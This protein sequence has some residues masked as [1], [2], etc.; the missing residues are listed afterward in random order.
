MAPL[1][2]DQ[3]RTLTARRIISALSPFVLARQAGSH[4]DYKH[5]DGRRVTASFHHS[6]DTFRLKTLRSVREI[7][8]QWQWDDLK[9][10]GLV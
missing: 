6:F 3:L 7:Q 1:D 9:R 4:R 5:P 10:L 8:A 2:Y